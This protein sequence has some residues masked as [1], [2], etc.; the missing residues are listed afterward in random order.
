MQ[1]K[2]C[3][4]CHIEHQ[5]ES[6]PTQMNHAALLNRDLWLAQ[7]EALARPRLKGVLNFLSSKM[8]ARDVHTLSSLQCVACHALREPHGKL[9]GEEC[10][11]CHALASWTISG[12]RHPAM[13][14]TTCAECHRPPPS[15]G[16][17]HFTMVSQSVA[18]KN[19]SV[20]QCY[21][22]HA[23]DSWNNIRNKGYYDHH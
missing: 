7:P 6:A 18:E 22:C 4:I 19:A 17:M 11:N 9:F 2:E 5:G 16:M 12:F 14:S 23:T 20:E 1:V 21:A 8:R 15:H 3:A 13:T 10:S